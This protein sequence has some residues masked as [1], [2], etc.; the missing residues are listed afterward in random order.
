MGRGSEEGRRRKKG[1]G[2]EKWVVSGELRLVRGSKG[3]GLLL[4][5]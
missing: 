3:K 5:M 1:E 2:R 4:R